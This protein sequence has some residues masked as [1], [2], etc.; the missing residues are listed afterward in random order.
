MRMGQ[1]G[2]SAE[3]LV[4]DAPEALLADI[5][6]HYGEERAA[7]RIARAIVAERAR[8]RITSTLQLAGIV[9]GCLPRKKPGQSHPATRS[10]Q[11]LRI[12]VNDELGQL[13]EALAAAERALKPGGKLAVV[14][15]HSIEDRIVKRYLAERA[16]AGGGGSRHAPAEASREP[17]LILTPKK[18][19]G[20]DAEEIEANPRARSAKLRV[21][22]RTE[23]SAG[24]VDPARLGLPR[25]EGLQ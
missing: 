11:A 17:G 5:L 18:A 14:T 20:P 9:E 10:F 13:V 24:D 25:V 7:R 23:A 4:N 12:A 6:Y 1:A 2:L 3:D 19:I 8:G 22:T 21:A 16:S 15:F